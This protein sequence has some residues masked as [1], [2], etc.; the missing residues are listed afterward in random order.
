MK[1]ILNT[2]DIRKKLEEKKAI[3]SLRVGVKQSDTTD[4][5]N[6]DR[7]DLAQDYFSK[8][9][10]IALVDQLEDTLEQVEAALQRLDEGTYGRCSQCGE[11][12]SP[13]RLAVLPYADLCMDCQETTH[14]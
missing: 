3:L 1:N 10:Q 6:P 9:R 7:S 4:I 13:E 5:V 12:I 14:E 11:K 2:K 8:E